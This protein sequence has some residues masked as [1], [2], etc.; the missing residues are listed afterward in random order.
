[1][2]RN[3]LDKRDVSEHIQEALDNIQEIK[4]YH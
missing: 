1:M 2:K 3:Y 4:A